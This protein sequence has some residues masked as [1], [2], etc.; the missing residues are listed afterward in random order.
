MKPA[1]LAVVVAALVVGCGGKSSSPTAPDG[2]PA[3]TP[4]TPRTLFVA[5]N[6]SDSNT[7]SQDSPWFTIRHAV[8]RLRAGDTLYLRGGLYWEDEQAIDSLVATVPGGTSWS[9]PI[10]IAGYPGESVT[11]QPPTAIHGLRL[12]SSSQSYLIFQDFT[13]DYSNN[14]TNLEG[15]YLSG[16]AHHNRFLRLEVRYAKTFGIVF[17]NNG[18]NSGFNEVIECDI[19]HTGNGS[20]DPLNGHGAYV[21]TS[22]NL[23]RGNTVHDNEGYGLDFYDNSGQPTVSRNVVRDNQIFNNGTHGG[24]A[25][26]VVVAWGENNRVVGNS[27]RQNPGGVMVYTRSTGT[28]VSGNTIYDNSPLEG[29]FIQGAVGTIVKNNTIYSN[30]TNVVNLGQGTQGLG[31]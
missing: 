7:G 27:I 4:G 8:S 22:D 26:G 2:T 10:T 19:H 15:I 3:P 9:N 28:E 1:L 6:G 30:G 12:T 31:P 24:T 5:R 11:I 13:L 20:G 14:P 23:F 21:F 29:L 25:Y 18:G 17:S 16:G